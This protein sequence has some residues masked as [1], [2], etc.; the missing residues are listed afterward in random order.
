VN[1]TEIRAGLADALGVVDGVRSYD[2]MPGKL[3]TSSSSS[4]AVVVGAPVNGA[5]VEYLEASSGGQAKVNFELRVFVQFMDLAQSQRR[6]DDLLSAGTGETLSLFDAIRA[7]NTLGGTVMDCAPME[8][9]GAEVVTVA[10]VQYLA[11]SLHCLVL[12]RRT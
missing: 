2:S 5:Y 4:T 10:E 12:A 3:A 1:L 11:A 6:L 7:D 8:S 9:T